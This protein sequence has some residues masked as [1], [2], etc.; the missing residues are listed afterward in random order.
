MH[1][2]LALGAAALFGGSAAIGVAAD[3]KP[4]PTQAP[5]KLDRKNAQLRL[6]QVVFRHGARTPLTD[7]AFLWQGQDWNMSTILSG[8]AAKG[9]LTIVGQLQALEL[10]YWLRQQYIDSLGFLP[11]SYKP[12][13]LAARTTNFSRTRATLAGVLTGL[14]PGHPEPI[15]VTTSSDLDEI[16]YADTKRCPHL[17]T[18]MTASEAMLQEDQQ[19]GHGGDQCLHLPSAG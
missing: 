17:K 16:M 7:D 19:A 2:R 4:A 5:V 8:G 15:P 11:A 3:T 12:G 1:R 10:G 14:Y 18:L 9:E 13:V 6:V